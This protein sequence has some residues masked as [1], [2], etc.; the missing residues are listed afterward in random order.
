MLMQ[1]FNLI[2]I[3]QDSAP[4]QLWLP[5]VSQ[6]GENSPNLVAIYGSRLV[7]KPIR[8]VNGIYN[9]WS[10]ECTCFMDYERPRPRAGAL[11]TRVFIIHKALH[12][13][14]YPLHI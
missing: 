13:M 14:L 11:G 2:A 8:F 3:G 5:R 1:A 10:M 7:S 6:C 4:T 9:R 12:T